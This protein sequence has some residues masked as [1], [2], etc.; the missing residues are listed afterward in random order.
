MDGGGSAGVAG[1]G[2]ACSAN[3]L[4]SALLADRPVDGISVCHPASLGAAACGTSGGKGSLAGG[5][6]SL[7]GGKGSLAGG[8]A[9]LAG[10][11]PSLTGGIASLVGGIAS[12]G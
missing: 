10:G 12:L 11:I 5:I 1:S 3:E 7:V 8:I 4:A 6:P 9:S 2:V